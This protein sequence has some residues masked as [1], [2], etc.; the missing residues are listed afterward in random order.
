MGVLTLNKSVL[1]RLKVLESFGLKDRYQKKQIEISIVFPPTLMQDWLIDL[2]TSV[3]NSKLTL[4]TQISDFVTSYYIMRILSVAILRNLKHMVLLWIFQKIPRVVLRSYKHLRFSV[5]NKSKRIWS[6][7]AENY[8]NTFD[9][10]C[11]SLHKPK[12]QLNTQANKLNTQRA[13]IK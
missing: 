1:L 10:T 13:P 11:I 7:K 2:A 4:Y 8:S 9:T 6:K 12:P 5:L 3:F